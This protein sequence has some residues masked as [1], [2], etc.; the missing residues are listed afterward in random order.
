MAGTI[1][2]P[3]LQDFGSPDLGGAPLRPSKA[4]KKTGRKAA[5]Q[6]SGGDALVFIAMGLVSAALGLGLYAHV[7]LQFPVAL[8][9]ALGL[10]VSTSFLH[11][12]VRR[13][14]GVDLL[15]RRVT[16][17]EDAV[18]QL[19]DTDQP[20]PVGQ[21]QATPAA[22]ADR[23][24]AH[25][26]TQEV[27]EAV[28]APVEVQ[29]GAPAWTEQAP[30]AQPIADAVSQAPAP[31]L[32]ERIRVEQTAPIADAPQEQPYAPKIEEELPP[33]YTIPNDANIVFGREQA[34]AP[35]EQPAQAPAF[36]VREDV[37]PAVD[38]SID[39]LVRQL[40]E[41]LNTTNTPQPGALPE[42]APLPA[43]AAPFEGLPAQPPQARPAPG[44]P[45][46]RRDA[47][48]TPLISMPGAA[49]DEEPPSTI[50]PL[51]QAMREAAE[52]G[53]MDIYLQPILSIDDRKV[54]F[55]EVLGRIKA[56][57]GNVIAME[58]HQDLARSMGILAKL[59]RAALVR[60]ARLLR[61]LSERRQAQPLF[62]NIS[63]E[64]LSDPTFMREFVEFMGGFRDI[65]P[66]LIFE[67]EQQALAGIDA[68]A[69]SSLRALSSM[70]F[71]LSIDQVSKVES[72]LAVAREFEFSFLKLPLTTFLS[73]Q[74]P[75]SR[76]RALAIHAAARDNNL[77]LVID[78]IERKDQL[79]AVVSTGANLGQGYLF[80]EPKPLLPQVAAEV[81]DATVAA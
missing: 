45:A 72:A 81:A 57:N 10:F 33:A 2:T 26:I 39:G 4:G 30:Q 51:G 9:A 25:D 42:P 23:T 38:R 20:E 28:D 44:E 36:G 58:D 52:R 3:Q 43:S 80:S 48:E 18:S 14:Q 68:T 40:T 74:E 32:A 5:R 1:R 49:S 69:G 17:L 77:T 76:A 75:E 35:V 71:R 27:R 56:P 19:E 11:V 78:Q 53:I 55:F 50:D 61:K 70:G 41:G 21:I 54:R 59:D 24:P 31:S 8:I 13:M 73:G 62:C 47:G 60:S 79:A 22:S 6:A 63:R 15:D 16:A 29:A 66:F 12:F 64:S 65:A 34:A 37:A 7:G 46:V 67:I